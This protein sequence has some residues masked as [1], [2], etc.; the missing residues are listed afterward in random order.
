LI[1]AHYNILQN[2]LNQIE[3]N[4]AK[5]ILEKRELWFMQ[6][7]LVRLLKKLVLPTIREN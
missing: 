3:S 7:T 4:R 2:L 6:L 5:T 1:F